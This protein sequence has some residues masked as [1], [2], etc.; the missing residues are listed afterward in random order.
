MRM[1]GVACW[2]VSLLAPNWL[3]FKADVCPRASKLAGPFPGAFRPVA[4]GD[5]IRRTVLAGPSG[6]SAFAIRIGALICAR[7]LRDQ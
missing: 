1:I 6:V 5:D 7:V 2:P 4:G 3:Q